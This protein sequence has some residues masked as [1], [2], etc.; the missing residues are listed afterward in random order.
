MSAIQSRISDMLERERPDQY[1]PVLAFDDS[2]GV[3]LCD[4]GHIGVVYSG[5]PIFGADDTTAEMLKGAFSIPLPAGS[6]I[7]V[8]MIGM[9]DIDPYVER[10]VM[11][12]EAGL[13]RLRQPE[14]HQMLSDFYRRRAD[15]IDM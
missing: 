9:P 11:R 3:F 15:Y 12:R 7:Q 10:Y 2:N 8:S 13:S 6:F 14:T 1:V 5:M 4:D